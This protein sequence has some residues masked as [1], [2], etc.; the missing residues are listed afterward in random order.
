MGAGVAY[1]EMVA[2]LPGL[3]GIT[4]DSLAAPP[5]TAGL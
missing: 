1:L 4:R 3:S 2:V 5:E